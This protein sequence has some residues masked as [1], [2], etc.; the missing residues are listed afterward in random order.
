[1][2][3]RIM[4]TVA[5]VGRLATLALVAMA[6]HFPARRPCA[7]LGREAT[8][9]SCLYRLPSRSAVCRVLC[10]VAVSSVLLCR[11]QQYVLPLRRQQCVLLRCRQQS[12]LAAPQ[13]AECPAVSPSPE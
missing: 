10:R 5:P 1:M 3:R 4:A 8:S 9:R 13:S 12:V 11:R 7:I 6:G 2:E